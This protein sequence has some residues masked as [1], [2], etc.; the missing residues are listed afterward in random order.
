MLT[1]TDQSH[2]I[3]KFLF[4]LPRYQRVLRLPLGLSGKESAYQCRRCRRRGF[5]PWVGKIPWSRKWQPTSVFLPGLSHGQ[6]SL[7]GYSPW[8]CK[9]SDITECTHTHTHTR[10]LDK[11]YDSICRAVKETQVSRRD[12]WAPWEVL[13]QT[14][15]AVLTHA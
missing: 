1:K 8:G 4:W 10:N 15:R 7:V 12:L 5:D 3:D 11:R 6:R 2:S 9:A 14:E 13:G